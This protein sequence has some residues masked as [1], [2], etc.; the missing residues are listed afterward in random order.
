MGTTI[1]HTTE[2]IINPPLLKELE[3]AYNGQT[4][5]PNTSIAHK[6]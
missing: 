5:V 2:L 4:A 3:H 6:G 1:E